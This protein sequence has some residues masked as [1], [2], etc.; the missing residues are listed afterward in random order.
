MSGAVKPFIQ[1]FWK[2]FVRIEGIYMANLIAL[3]QIFEIFWNF[4]FFA[5]IP[6]FSL[7]FT[8]DWKHICLLCIPRSH[9]HR[10]S[11]KVNN[12]LR[13]LKK[14]TVQLFHGIVYRFSWNSPFIKLRRL[15][16]RNPIRQS[17][18]KY[19]D[20]FE[21]QLNDDSDSEVDIQFRLKAN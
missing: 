1:M 17:N 8:F 19:D 13:S 21:F 20:N 12:L 10:H 2:L 3:L 14:I 9:R 16:L 7:V 11:Y 4:S 18:S 6:F 5:R 15:G